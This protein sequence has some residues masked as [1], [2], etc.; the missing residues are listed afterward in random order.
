MSWLDGITDKMHMG[1]FWTPGV[2]DGQGGLSVLQ[3]MGSQTVAQD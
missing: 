3:F 1:F 2:S